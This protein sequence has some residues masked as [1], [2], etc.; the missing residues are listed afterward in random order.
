MEKIWTQIEDNQPDSQGKV[1]RTDTYIVETKQAIRER[2]ALEHNFDFGSQGEQGSHRM[3]SARVWVSETD[4]GPGIPDTAA[5][6]TGIDVGR[7]WFKPST[8]QLYVRRNS[9]WYGVTVNLDSVLLDILSLQ[10]KASPVNADGFLLMDSE[11]P[12]SGKI[13]T[14]QNLAET[15]LSKLDWARIWALALALGNKTVPGLEDKVFVIDSADGSKGKIVTLQ[16]VKNLVLEGK[17]PADFAT[18]AQGAK[19]DAALPAS[20]FNA[21]TIVSLVDG[22]AISPESVNDYAAATSESSPLLTLNIGPNQTVTLKVKKP[23]TV[24]FDNN[25][26]GNLRVF[27]FG[28]DVNYTLFGVTTYQVMMLNPGIYTIYSEHKDSGGGVVKVLG[29]YGAVGAANPGDIWE[30]V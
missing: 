15:V 19:A 2:I 27:L 14:L 24:L 21:G 28:H 4:P 30:V 6:E 8:Q 16:A 17:S 7:I 25:G 9:A 1:G 23:L 5:A 12:G 18:A 3:G 20:E 22:Q 13:V 26:D 29:V 11:A 10:M